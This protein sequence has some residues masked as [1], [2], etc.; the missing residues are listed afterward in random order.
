MYNLLLVE[1]EKPLLEKIACHVDWEDNGYKVYTA[2]NGKQALKILNNVR[3]DILVTDIKMPDISGIRLIEEIKDNKADM[4][5]IIISGHAEFE[6]AQKSI[7][8]GV[9]DYLLK[10]FHSS[11]LLEVVNRARKQLL[12]KRKEKE[13]LK[14]F[15]QE[16]N[17]ILKEND[18]L[19]S[20]L[21]MFFNRDR[22]EFFREYSL[23]IKNENMFNELKNGR[24]EDLIIA[25]KKLF[26]DINELNINQESALF[27]IHTVV[28][29]TLKNIK[30]MG[31]DLKEII[32]FMELGNKSIDVEKVSK[33]T[34]ETWLTGFLVKVSQYIAQQKSEDR[35]LVLK[36][37]EAVNKNLSSGLTL[38]QLAE[39]FNLSNSSL[40]QLFRKYTG[41]NFSEYLDDIRINKARELLKTTGKKVYEIADEIGFDDPYYFSSWFKKRTGVSPTTYRENFILFE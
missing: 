27:I 26:E 39:E 19:D 33:E 34:M 2:R 24:E 38:N 10:P 30:E 28:L 15:K 22:D 13:D 21:Q 35:E 18:Q 25:I 31:F 6:Y 17:K 12:K 20:K 8:L 29:L 23:I 32:D 7:R 11:R 16:L 41:K 1:D 36:V 5:T 40:S 37:K 3:I 4:S 14:R 9:T